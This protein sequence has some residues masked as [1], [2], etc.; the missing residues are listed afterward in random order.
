MKRYLLGTASSVVFVII[1]AHASLAQATV[2][3]YL[4]DMTPEQI[5]EAVKNTAPFDMEKAR[6]E[7]YDSIV[8]G[9]EDEYQRDLQAWERD[10]RLNAGAYAADPSKN[11]WPKPE[12]KNIS[13]AVLRGRAEALAQEWH[14]S[15]SNQLAAAGTL[16]SNK[17]N[18]ARQQAQQDAQARL[19][20]ERE[21]AIARVMASATGMG[22]NAAQIKTYVDMVRSEINDQEN[23]ARGLGRAVTYPYSIAKTMA[24]LEQVRPAMAQQ[25]QQYERQMAELAKNG[26]A[27]T[28]S[29]GA[30]SDGQTLNLDY[31]YSVKSDG[32]LYDAGGNKVARVDLGAGL[33]YDLGGRQITGGT[34]RQFLDELLRGNGTV[35]G[36]GASAQATATSGSSASSGGT[37][38]ASSSSSASASGVVANG[39][40]APSRPSVLNRRAESTTIS[41]ADNNEDLTEEVKKLK[42]PQNGAVSSKQGDVISQDSE[43]GIADRDAR[44]KTADD[45]HREELTQYLPTAKKP[46]PAGM[47]YGSGISFS[48]YRAQG[49]DVDPQAQLAALN[50]E[51]YAT[52]LSSYP[53][54]SVTKPLTEAAWNDH[55]QLYILEA[56][57]FDGNSN[58][59]NV[60]NLFAQQVAIRNKI[61][62]DKKVVSYNW[63]N[64][65]QCTSN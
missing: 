11:T 13:E 28:W 54:D 37:S 55:H 4:P 48:G 17:E 2:G 62:G 40:I 22:M 15:Y 50:R 18:E 29:R 36:T 26:V 59:N 16:A 25:S 63:E 43:Q 9:Y 23:E 27:S 21:A 19:T 12:R 44:A 51:T 7:A 20:A 3:G 30:L 39:A 52:Y 41:Y 35:V 8:K 31:G 6:K 58:G 24:A 46:V 57:F 42:L 53:K 32:Y 49:Y 38:A 1:S 34:Q 60:D 33:F 5:R 65:V 61:C 64:A 10:Q 56:Q 47:K 14:Q 45:A